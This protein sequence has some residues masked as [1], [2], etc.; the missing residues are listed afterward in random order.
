MA[1]ASSTC[2]AV[3]NALATVVIGKFSSEHD[4][5]RRTPLAQLEV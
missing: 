5:A 1:P 2:N 4:P 3:G